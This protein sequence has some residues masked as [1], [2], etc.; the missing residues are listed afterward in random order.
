MPAIAYKND[1]LFVEDVDVAALA[2]E[3]GTPFYA[4][5]TS[6]ISKAYENLVAAIAH[7]RV[8]IH[9]AVKANSNIAVIKV[10]SRAGAGMDI[11][12]GGELKR[13]LKAGV[14]A[15]DII[16]SGVGKTEEEIGF[17]LK[18][19][20]GQFNIESLPEMEILARLAQGMKR[21]AKVALRINPG[22]DAGGH[23]KISTGKEEDKFGINWDQVENAYACVSEIPAL[24]AVGLTTHIG[25]Q[26]T[27]TAPFQNAAAR[28]ED[29]VKRLRA[30]DLSVQRVSLGG[31]LGISY[32]GEKIPVAEFGR[33]VRGFAER[34]D[35]EVELEPGRH[36]VGEAGILVTKVLYV[37][38]A[39]AKNFLVVDAAMNDLIRP[40]LYEAHH[41]IQPVTR[42]QDNALETYDVVGPVC[43]TGD[44]FA[45]DRQLPITQANDLIALLCAGAYGASMSSTYNSR[46]LCPEILILGRKSAVIRPRLTI[47]QQLS[48]ENIPNWL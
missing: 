32:R 18:K 37:K 3:I 30:R 9:Y 47:E 26:I 12:S 24:E 46:A 25:S 44:Y 48:W 36:L 31:G 23:A 42:P 11:V 38:R 22:I 7:P 1:R 20:I 10:L 45:K 34:L 40:T 19:D 43:E 21:R 4:Y 16:F 13:C 14:K 39:A 5:S 33:L 29:M 27:E 17:A 8:K 6:A 28:L 35:C 41:H 2:K 15:A